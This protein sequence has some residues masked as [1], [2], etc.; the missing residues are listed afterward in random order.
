MFEP[1]K[2]PGHDDEIKATV[3]DILKRLKEAETE[4]KKI[5]EDTSNRDLQLNQQSVL[6]DAELLSLNS[7]IGN[8]KNEIKNIISEMQNFVKLLRLKAKA[9][10]FDILNDKADEWNPE[11]FITK[12]E[13]E[14]MLH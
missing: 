4:N 13:F 12:N 14:K 5:I 6:I 11:K 9:R 7:E 1:S 2:T 8:L 10:E 3:K